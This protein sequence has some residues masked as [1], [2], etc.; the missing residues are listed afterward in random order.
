M[1]K[2]KS[3]RKLKTKQNQHWT[4]MHTAYQNLWDTAKAVLKR[5]FVTLNAH[6]R[7]EEKSLINSLHSHLKNLKE[8]E[9]KKPT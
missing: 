6:I 1:S 3:Q 7:K 4:D 9:Q 2:K 8:E 5:K